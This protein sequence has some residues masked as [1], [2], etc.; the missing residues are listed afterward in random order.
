MCVCVLLCLL[1]LLVFGV[2]QIREAA[3][4]SDGS[5]NVLAA[6]VDAAKVRCTLGEISSAMEDV[7]GRYILSSR[8]VGGVY[9]AAYPDTS[10][11]ERV[12]GLVNRFEDQAGRRPRMLVVKLGQDG[13]DR[14]AKIIANG[15]ADLGF[16][17]DLGPLFQTPQEAARQALDADVHVVGVSTQAAGHRTAVPELIKELRRSGA[18]YISVIVGGVIPEEDHDFLRS[19]GVK[20]IFGPGTR[21]INAAE[22]VLKHLVE[23]EKIAR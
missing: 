4:C 16:D 6:A 5:K 3:Q 8:V 9:R 20:L 10:E 12:E 11:I 2:S 23:E 1:V 7:W 22:T 18:G 15:F 19:R 17:V 13:H 21:V 14:G